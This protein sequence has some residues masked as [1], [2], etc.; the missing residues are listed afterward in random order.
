MNWPPT[1][2]RLPRRGAENPQFVEYFRQSTEQELGA[3]PWAAVRP[4]AVPVGS[5]PAG[6]SVDL[7]LDP[8]RLMLPAW[9]GWEAALS[10]ALERGRRRTAGADA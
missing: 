5:K 10:K 6:D 4:S 1:A 2:S 7:R 8:D 3:C 9:L